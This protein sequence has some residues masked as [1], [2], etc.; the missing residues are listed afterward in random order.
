MS[1]QNTQKLNF[2]DKKTKK[3]NII[4]VNDEGAPVGGAGVY[5]QQLTEEL[6]KRG[7]SVRILSSNENFKVKP[8]RT[9]SFK[10]IDTTS[11]TRIWL[12]LYNPSSKKV[13]ESMQRFKPDIIHLHSVM[14]QSSPSIFYGFKN[15]PS[16]MT[17]HDNL[18][19][20]PLDRLALGASSRKGLSK[21]L[22][23]LRVLGFRYAYE[24]IRNLAYGLAIRKVDSFISPSEYINSE[25]KRNHPQTTVVKIPNGTRLLSASPLPKTRNKNILFVGRLAVEKG[26]SILVEAFGIIAKQDPHATLTIVGDGP[27]AAQLKARATQLGISNRI[28]FAGYVNRDRIQQYYHGASLVCIPSLCEESFSLVGIEALSAGRVVIAS[29]V[30]GISEWLDDGVNGYFVPPGNE[31]ILA[32]KILSLSQDSKKL[33]SMSK[34]AA[35]DAARFD[36]S[37]NAKRVEELYYKVIHSK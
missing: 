24:A 10:A 8:F 5:L 11:L 27:Q 36:C 16:V 28:T 30:G 9:D 35:K 17:L 7:H 19:T 37:L 21:Q 34:M 4:M 33:Q 3:L 26:A 20:S 1:R 22:F 14:G 12:Q 31:R 29:E 18:I 6:H 2:Q 25:M 32:K 23:L 13:L 15:T